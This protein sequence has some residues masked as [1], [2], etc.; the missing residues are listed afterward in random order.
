MM[1]NAFLFVEEYLNIP[2]YARQSVPTRPAAWCVP[3]VQSVVRLFVC[4]SLCLCRLSFLPYRQI[5]STVSYNTR[6]GR[7]LFFTARRLC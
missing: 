4:V 1:I 7:Y 2:F 5:V 3:D 6:I